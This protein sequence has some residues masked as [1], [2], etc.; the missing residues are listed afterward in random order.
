ML[1]GRHVTESVLGGGGQEVKKENQNDSVGKKK[2]VWITA[3]SDPPMDLSF[4]D[5][6]KENYL[7]LFKS[8][9]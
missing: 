3:T 2:L 6:I 8:T 5:Y 4:P 9:V 7:Q 1:T